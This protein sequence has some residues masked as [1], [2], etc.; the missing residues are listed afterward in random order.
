MGK[1]LTEEQKAQRAQ[2]RAEKKYEEAKAKYLR[3]REYQLKSSKEEAI[4]HLGDRKPFEKFEIGQE[5]R[6]GNMEAIVVDTELDGR[7]VLVEYEPVALNRE[8][9]LRKKEDYEIPTDRS[10]KK[11]QKLISKEMDE[12]SKNSPKLSVK[13]EYWKEAFKR[14]IDSILHSAYFNGFDFDADYQR[15]HVWTL[16]DKVSLIDSIFNDVDFGQISVIDRPFNHEDPNEPSYEV[17]DGKQRLTAIIEFYEGVFPYKGLYYRELHYSD[18]YKFN[19]VM[20]NFTS[21][22]GMTQKG[23]YDYFLKMNKKGHVQSEEHLKY[24]QELMDNCED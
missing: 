15:G 24:V 3:N 18:K 10:W 13:T 14:P 20:V 2:K 12:K 16:E 23:K 6:F 11:W 9:K 19:D 22:K 8:E 17:V 21:I 4:N 5:V 1:K 7:I